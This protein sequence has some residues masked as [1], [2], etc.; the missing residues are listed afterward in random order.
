MRKPLTTLSTVAAAALIATVLPAAAAAHENT[1]LIEVNDGTFDITPGFCFPA[2]N[3]AG[4]AGLGGAQFR[5]NIDNCEVTGQFEGQTL[6]EA[7]CAGINHGFSVG[8]LEGLAPVCGLVSSYT[9]DA[10][11]AFPDGSANNQTFAGVT[12]NES[13]TVTNVGGALEATGSLDDDDP[14][15]STE[16]DHTWYAAISAMPIEGDCGTAPATKFSFRSVALLD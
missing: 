13:L 6:V 16:G 9:S 10:T 12:R 8:T 5:V 3:L 1:R 7:P 2:V 4:C 11:T 15:T 14:D